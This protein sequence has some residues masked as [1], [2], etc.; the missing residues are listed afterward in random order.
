ML[1]PQHALA[2][3][4]ESLAV[5]R[6]VAVLGDSSAGLGERILDLG[7]RSVLLWDPD[8]DRAAREAQRAP[9]GVVVRGFPL[10]VADVRQG[11]VDLALVPDL[12][13]FDDAQGVLAIVRQAVGDRGVAVV[14]AANRDVA[15]ENA[16]AF[17]YYE[18]F[19]L[20]ANE[21]ADVRMVAQLPFYG[22]A[23][24]ELGRE[25]EEAP[26]V[27]VDAQLADSGRAPELF[28]AVAGAVGASLE[29]YAIIELPAP[30]VPVEEEEEEE[31]QQAEPHDVAAR[32]A[33]AQLR[34]HALEGQLDETRTRL[35][36]VEQASAEAL[37]LQAAQLRERI[38]RVAELERA[39]AMRAGQIGDLSVEVEE[40]RSAAEA[41][42]VAAAQVEEMARRADQAER[43][44]GVL[45]A[46]VTR[47]AEAHAGEHARFEEVLRDRAQAIRML[48]VELTRR[49]R[50]VRELV[51]ALEE[52]AGRPPPVFD[53]PAA[54]TEPPPPAPAE[55]PPA[56]Q[57]QEEG[58]GGRPADD[59]LA[60][61]NVIL[62]EKLDELALELARREGEAQAAAWSV[63]ELER[64]LAQASESA[65]RAS[66]SASTESGLPAPAGEVSQRLAAALDE[67]D[68]LRQTVALEHAQ[69]VRVET[70]EELARARAEIQRQAALLEKLGHREQ[71]EGGLHPPGK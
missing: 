67:L 51:D 59:A 71:S 35:A 20:V 8:E 61:E 68:V 21:F 19:D 63:S 26:G 46:E 9:A 38:E 43:A 65:T 66:A 70:G 44:V 41:G 1:H 69:R 28:V 15:A 40:M 49:D 6:R 27:S 37:G 54:R 32:I 47:I 4:A 57:I 16:R 24:A 7:A 31:E 56:I 2:V 60:Q 17:D 39:L 36:Q 13:L 55:P 3:Y 48:E 5:D 22:V 10:D 34:A 42:R 23:L 33:E 30:A 53:E 58:Y 11:T 50:M 12:G 14:A 25:E 18:L 52:N 45:Q 62:R 64:R 29:P